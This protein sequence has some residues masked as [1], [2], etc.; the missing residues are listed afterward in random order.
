MKYYH[1]LLFGSCTVKGDNCDEIC[2]ALLF[3]FDTSLGTDAINDSFKPNMINI[4]YQY[5]HRHDKAEKTG[6]DV[7]H[8][9]ISLW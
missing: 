1:V 7:Y 6:C 3:D 2:I 4:K 5:P 8:V 9:G